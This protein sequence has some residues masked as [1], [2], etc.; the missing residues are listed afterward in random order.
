MF[1]E[2][3]SLQITPPARAAMSSALE[4]AADANQVFRLFVKGYS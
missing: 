2:N 4:S 1:E 3:I